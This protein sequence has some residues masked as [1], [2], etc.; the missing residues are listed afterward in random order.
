MPQDRGSTVDPSHMS[1]NSGHSVDHS[2]TATLVRGPTERLPRSATYPHVRNGQGA[3][4]GF[5]IGSRICASAKSAANR[6]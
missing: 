6:R 3:P 2:P 4:A 5:E 1:I